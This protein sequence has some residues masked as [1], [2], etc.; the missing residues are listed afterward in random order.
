VRTTAHDVNAEVR[1]AVHHAI[2]TG[3]LVAVVLRGD[4]LRGRGSRMIEG[5]P[6]A[7]ELARDGRERVVLSVTDGADQWVLLERLVCVVPRG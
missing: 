4:P 6:Y 2:E 3:Q 1:A 7:I 5:R